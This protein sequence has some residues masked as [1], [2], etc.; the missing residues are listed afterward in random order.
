MARYGGGGGGV[1]PVRTRSQPRISRTY[2][3]APAPRLRGNPLVAGP[4]IHLPGLRR[5]APPRPTTPSGHV[6]GRQD[7]RSTRQLVRMGNALGMQRL[8][9]QAGYPV[10]LDGVWGPQ[11][12][13]AYTHYASQLG[14]YQQQRWN[15]RSQQLVA[16]PGTP[17]QMLRHFGFAGATQMANQRAAQARYAH[18]LQQQRDWNREIVVRAPTYQ[19][20]GL[21]RYQGRN[22][23]THLTRYGQVIGGPSHPSVV[24]QLLG[25]A[26]HEI[27]GVPGK[28]WRATGGNLLGQ[29]FAA[30]GGHGSQEEVNRQLRQ[31]RAA[32]SGIGEFVAPAF[33]KPIEGKPIG[34]WDVANTALWA[35][36]PLRFA[37][38]G[39]EGVL[40]SLRAARLAEISGEAGRAEVLYQTARAAAR[41]G[42]PAA[43][44]AYRENVGL[45][46]PAARRLNLPPLTRTGRAFA[47]SAAIQERYAAI[48]ERLRR[49]EIT[50]LEAA[51]MKRGVRQ[52]LINPSKLAGMGPTGLL[53]RLEPSGKTLTP[54]ELTA[55][56]RAIFSQTGGF[57]PHE[58]VPEIDANAIADEILKEHKLKDLPKEMNTRKKLVA[59][60]E[61]VYGHVEEGAAYRD[62]YARSVG[63][64]RRIARRIKVTP[65]QLMDA[66]AVASQ[67]TSPTDEVRKAVQMIRQSRGEEHLLPLG[68]ETGEPRVYYG[69]TRPKGVAKEDYMG[70]HQQMKVDKI[71]AGEPWQTTQTPKI[72]NYAAN[73][74]EHMN[75]RAYAKA[76]PEG[77]KQPV[78]I[79]TH[80][81]NMVAPSLGEDPGKH[82]QQIADI[83]RHMGDQLGWSPAETQAAAWVPWKAR[84]EAYRAFER[85]GMAELPP[86]ERYLEM[87]GDA[88]ERAY[89]KYGP[90]AL[91]AEDVFF[92]HEKPQV[93]HTFNSKIAQV[94]SEIRP[95]EEFWPERAAMYDRLSADEKLHYA[96]LTDEAIGHEFEDALG[97]RVEGK[98]AGQ[99]IWRGE[100]SPGIAHHVFVGDEVTAGTEAELNALAAAKG[101]AKH[102]TSVSWGRPL[103]PSEGEFK[104]IHWKPPE[105]ADPAALS[106]QLDREL[107]PGN[108]GFIHAPDGGYYVIDFNG[109]L[110]SRASV[111]KALRDLGGEQ[112]DI[113][114]DGGYTIDARIA[115]AD[116]WGNRYQAAIEDLPAH[117]RSDLELAMTRVRARTDQIDEHFFGRKGA[118]LV[119]LEEAKA[120]EA[121]G[122]HLFHG[123]PLADQI[124]AER[125]LRVGDAHPT[126]AWMTAHPEYADFF[127]PGYE[128]N[129]VAIPKD[130]IPFGE[131]SAE[132]P[133]GAYG[134]PDD[135]FLQRTPGT[136]RIDRA[137]NRINRYGRSKPAPVEPGEDWYAHANP[138]AVGADKFSRDVA[139]GIARL[140]GHTEETLYQG[141]R[142]YDHMSLDELH[143]RAEELEGGWN[144][145]V[146]EWTK[147][148]G[149]P[150]DFKN[151]TAYQNATARKTMRR[152]GRRAPTVSEM[153]RQNAETKLQDALDANPEHPIAQAIHAEQEEAW[154]IRQEIARRNDE[155]FQQP[156]EGETK[157]SYVRRTSPSGHIT[158]QVRETGLADVGTVQHELMHH[159]RPFLTPE[160]EQVAREAAGLQPGEAWTREAEERFADGWLTFLHEGKDVPRNWK[161]ILKTMTPQMRRAYSV[162]DLPE[163]SD[164]ERAMYKTLGG[165]ENSSAIG[166]MLLRN[167]RAA[168]RLAADKGYMPKGNPRT[169]EEADAHL[170]ELDA[171]AQHEGFG[172][173]KVDIKHLKAGETT[174][175]TGGAAGER[176]RGQMAGRVL[177]KDSMGP[178]EY[179]GA[180]Q[181]VRSTRQAIKETEEARKPERARR[182]A[183][184]EAAFESAGG[185]VQGYFAKKAEHKGMYPAVHLGQEL[186]LNPDAVDTLINLIEHHPALENRG[187]SKTRAQDALMKLL[188][189][190][191]LQRNEQGLLER[192][193]GRELRPNKIRE[194]ARDLGWRGWSRELINL[195]RSLMATMDQSAM[196]RH[197]IMTLAHSPRVWARQ[198][199]PM[200]KALFSATSAEGWEKAMQESR[201]FALADKAGVAHTSMGIDPLKREEQYM[202]VM[203]EA[204]PGLGRIVKASDRSYTGALNAMR[205]GLFDKI[206][207]QAAMQG[208]DLSDEHLL[209]SIGKFVNS[210]TGRGDLGLLRKHTVTLQSLLFSPRLLASRINFFNPFYYGS[211]HPFAR[212]QALKSF[213]KL[214][215]GTMTILAAAKMAG[216]PI[217]LDPRSAD[218]AKIKRGN[219]R[220]D[221]LGGFQQPVVLLSTLLTGTRI[222]STTGL[223]EKLSGSGYAT[224]RFDVLLRFF[225]NKLA[226]V[227]GGFTELMQG[228]D[229]MNHEPLGWKQLG[230]PGLRHPFRAIEENFY[231]H[232]TVPLLLQDIS[233]LK[234]YQFGLGG[235]P[236]LGIGVESYGPPPKGEHYRNTLIT[237]SHKAGLLTP[238]KAVMDDAQWQGE[239]D[240]KITAGMSSYDKMKAAAEV[241]DQKYA[242]QEQNGP[243]APKLE[244]SI[245]TQAGAEAVYQELRPKIAP[246]YDHWKSIVDRVNKAKAQAQPVH[247]S[248]SGGGVVGSIE[249]GLGHVVHGITGALGS[250]VATPT[251]SAATPRQPAAHV[252]GLPPALGSAI[253]NAARRY[254]VPASTL[255]GIWRIE[256]GSTFPNPA[257]NSSGYGGLFGTTKWNASTQEQANYAAQTLSHLLSTHGGNMAAA[258]H[259]YSGG[260]YTSVPGAGGGWHAGRAAGGSQFAPAAMGGFAGPG[261]PGGGGDNVDAVLRVMEE[262]LA[263][264]SYDP[265]DFLSQTL[266]S[267][268]ENTPLQGNVQGINF[269]L[270]KGGKAA[271]AARGAIALAEH[272]LGTP[273]AWGGESPSGFDCSGLL[274]YVWARMGVR[275]P[276]TSQQQWRAG[277]RVGKGQLQPGDAVFFE[278]TASGPGHVGMYIG[279]GRFIESPHTGATVRIS[280]LRGYPGYM[281]ARRFR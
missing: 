142:P 186:G 277:R 109:R 235:L 166:Q 52:I 163:I 141:A 5:A 44:Q 281:G 140:G 118:H 121:Q 216:L 33:I 188:N 103:R 199:G 269:Q 151:L 111:T 90:E 137:L 245:T 69:L 108:V 179:I 32:A 73:H 120:L 233:S 271:G 244:K 96:R 226:P 97:M 219:T 50:R 46:T 212:R 133:F 14:R 207:H 181:Q 100:Y 239:L 104:G 232:H 99:G 243:I 70:S 234:G 128:R 84:N 205:L 115:K 4:P 17:Q 236:A 31:T 56:D 266:T 248:S 123:S 267:L 37:G 164:A 62:W 204:I 25:G 130:Q 229:P 256:S 64:T 18:Y 237:D 148:E 89:S 55:E 75:P 210:A 227:P 72:E 30:A 12:Q 38:A 131:G 45:L 253:Q 241:F 59:T 91:K 177:D 22:Y 78:T 13:A 215:G 26:A 53:K 28:L 187:W 34:A 138:Q 94:H 159:I 213:A 51:N 276:R 203:A 77:S 255:A 81:A 47:R 83:F 279:G 86:W 92:Q 112:V 66:R 262:Q 117:Q 200:Y 7:I 165:H 171:A 264:G 209:Q 135:V 146:D 174:E 150:G 114:W 76:F 211:L 40:A 79:D 172:T 145:M 260:G 230:P 251:A 8:L 214:I 190:Q 116:D 58:P 139:R 24:G 43:M 19:R 42:G 57:N 65:Q 105:G 82:Y 162:A 88:G 160:M 168:S 74:L 10:A 278:P 218:F 127:A 113:G 93:D 87:S 41:A 252:G 249:H 61:R 183:R 29:G 63:V 263:S 224:S 206:A 167:T 238:P 193:F 191:D 124:M 175:L 85:A 102:Q 154:R 15:E 223:K 280:N 259:A 129:I 67:L 158:G 2:H 60:I 1:A 161:D 156:A 21:T 178:H 16:H 3:P 222:S 221:F 152:T 275:I 261:Q 48:D 9:R 208:W 68:A 122:T 149:R 268:G 169:S 242:A 23:V 6:V 258:L 126:A 182:L 196:F 27:G 184:G 134:S 250:A 107:G 257:V 144:D 143:A 35:G 272:Y 101:M 20:P 11:S 202:S 119:N 246:A 110:G 220:I 173:R 153:M 270:P 49:G 254:N 180:K 125:R 157:G 54:E 192:I 198:F 189:G 201:S 132:H 71:L 36:G 194:F 247:Q 231:L 136:G 273:Y 197:G 80:M 195:P 240:N 95:D 106:D 274:Q 176:V 217:V 170:A 225:Q 155:F 147:A 228:Q 98:R 39:T 185:G 265:A